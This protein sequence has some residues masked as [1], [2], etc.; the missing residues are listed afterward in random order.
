M[1]SHL[2][3]AALF[4]M[5]PYLSGKA[6]NMPLKFGCAGINPLQEANTITDFSIQRLSN[7]RV[8]IIWHTKE[9]NEGVSY[10]VMRKHGRNTQYISL[11]EVQPKSREEGL[12]EYSFIDSNDY[13]DSSFYCLKKT[14]DD[15]V[16][17]SLAKGVE[18]VERER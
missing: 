5:Y 12:V 9:E 11:G 16:F 1:R 10:E 2:F 3:I 7:A 6:N 8:L 14:A 15:V 18:G 13:A 17:Y 4:I